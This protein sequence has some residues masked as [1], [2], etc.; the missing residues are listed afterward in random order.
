MKLTRRELLISLPALVGFQA[1]SET[2]FAVI[3]DLHHGLAPDA[4]PCARCGA[5]RHLGERGHAE[6]RRALWAHGVRGA[7][8]LS[9]FLL[10]GL[11]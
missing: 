5:N 2:R 11:G 9:I 7:S 6:Y 8:P 4:R 10:G 3:T 1:I